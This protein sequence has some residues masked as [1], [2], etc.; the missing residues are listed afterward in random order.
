MDA[1]RLIAL[2]KKDLRSTLRNPATL[3]MVIIFPLVLT[4]AFGLAFGAMGTGMESTYD[5]A[6]VDNDGTGLS[7]A[8]DF[9][10]NVDASDVLNVVPYADASSAQRDLAEGKI[11]A[12]VV[13]PANFGNA[14]QSFVD[15]PSNPASWTNTS[16]VLSLDSG[17]M[18]I[19]QALPPVLYQ[20]LLETLVPGATG[21]S[22]PVTLGSPSLV[23]ADKRSQFDYMAPGLYA[24]AGIFLIMIVAESFVEQ[25]EK[26]LLKRINVTPATAA[27]VIGSQTASNLVLAA[28]QTGV[29]LGISA[30]VGFRPGV[31]AD[32]YLM[33]F[34]LSMVFSLCAVGCGLITATLSKNTGMATGLSFVFIIP[35]MFLG[36]FVPVPADVGRFVPSYYFTDAVTSLLL[37]GAPVTSSTV[38]F[39]LAILGTISAALF[40]IGTLL[41]RKLGSK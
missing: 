25:K 16:L 23:S 40:I 18:I 39:D 32:A 33:V 24:F 38:L 34:A 28:M 13:I 3:F 35:L 37:R 4:L 12:I 8:G 10:A 6:V 15:D 31:G 5:V 19:T 1:N 29:V 36:T 7:W 30:A 26:G 27:D 41:Y 17:S 9:T 21:A 11:D 2:A 20:V 14:C 22:L